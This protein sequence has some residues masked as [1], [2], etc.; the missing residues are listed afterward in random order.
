M[1]NPALVLITG[2]LTDVK[3]KDL[4]SSSQEEFEWI[5]YARVIDDV[6]NRSGLNKEIFY[7]LRGNHDSYGVSKVGGMFDFYQK[8]SI[9]ARL[10]RTGTVQSI[11]LQVGSSK[12]KC[13]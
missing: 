6:A 5:E 12:H 3:S 7:D 4:L 10:G 8:H 1:V 13:N 9:N 11:T 2:D